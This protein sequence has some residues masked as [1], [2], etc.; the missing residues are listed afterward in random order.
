ME[1]MPGNRLGTA[2]GFDPGFLNNHGTSLGKLQ[3]TVLL[4]RTH[5]RWEGLFLERASKLSIR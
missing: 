1:N 5:L 4:N 3:C 2:S